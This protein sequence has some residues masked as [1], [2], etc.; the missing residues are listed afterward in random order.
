MNSDDRT[1]NSLIREALVRAAHK[2][3]SLE[4]FNLWGR[5][6]E[7]RV[8]VNPRLAA[9]IRGLDLPS[10]RISG[11]GANVHYPLRVFKRAA[12]ALH[13]RLRWSPVSIHQQSAYR[14]DSP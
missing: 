14:S 1:I 8:T 4:P 12:R 10:V 13:R 7:P 3:S 2:E 5:G 9:I 11:Y 6:H